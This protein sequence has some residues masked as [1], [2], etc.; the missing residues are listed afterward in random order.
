MATGSSM[1]V[2]TDI[3]VDGMTC[4]ACASRVAA[5]LEAVEAVA[6]ARVNFASGRATVLHDGSTD[7][8]V[9]RRTIEQAGYSAPERLQTHEEA[10]LRRV[11]ALRRRLAGA[12]VLGAPI[13]AVSMLPSLRFDGW[14]WAAMVASAAVIFG[15]GWGFHRAAVRNLRHWAATMDTLVSLGTTAAWVWSAVVLVAGVDDGHVYFETGTVIV[16]LVVLGRWLEGRAT[17]R[18][19]EAVRALARLGASTARLTDGTEIPAEDLAVGMRFVVRPGERIATDGVVVSGASAVDMS[20]VTGEPVP[21]EVAPGDEVIGATVNADGSLE[22]EATRVGADTALA[23]IVRLVDEAQGGRAAVQRLADRVAGVFVPAVV[24]LAA[25]TLGVWFAAGAAASDGFT[26]AVA[27]LIISCPCALGLATPLAVMVGTGR[28][29]QLGVII[30]GAEV[31]EDTRRVDTVILDKTGTVTEGRLEVV[32]IVAV[33][34][35]DAAAMGLLAGVLESR[36]EHPVG[37]AIARRWPLSINVTDFLNRPGLGVV[38][39]VDGAQVRVGRRPLFGAVPAELDEAVGAAEARGQTAVLVGRG[40][41]AEAV[42]ALAD[43]VKP[44]SRPAVQ[45][46]R[47]M[48]LEVSLITGDNSRTAAWVGDAVG[49][50]DM[51]AEV[52]PADK[53]DAVTR[54]QEAG[55]RVAMVGDGIN[56]APALAQADLGI[57]VGTGTDVAIEASDITVVGGDLRAVPDAIALSRRTLATIKV[58]LFWAFAYNVAAIPLAATGI[59]SP[60]A[61]AAA[62]GLS[63]LF[64]VSNSLRL[65]RFRSLRT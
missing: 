51:T 39:R 47:D 13:T 30:K 36:S 15:S 37:A 12:V 31:L 32:D 17:R 40:P 65:R 19:G 10:E 42:I 26:A 54:L 1:K 28:G 6:D 11:A 38:G 22:V 9:L 14:R 25:V 64:V 20:M 53:A 52:L 16:A 21:V 41:T 7:D 59:L 62:M 58:N 63:S 48:G 57:A 3:R 45:Q 56:D 27:V 50:E 5:A 43:T 24:V 44:T 29:A 35:L 8:A 55:R 2:R 61:A 46:L 33:A 4:A 60:M 18:S 49:V 23:Q 34:G